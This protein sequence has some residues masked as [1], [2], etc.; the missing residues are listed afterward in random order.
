MRRLPATVAV[1]AIAT[2][3]AWWALASRRS[4]PGVAP[5]PTSGDATSNDEQPPAL[6]AAAGRE[7]VAPELGSHGSLVGIVRRGVARIA[8]RVEIRDPWS[9]F[10]AQGPPTVA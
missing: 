6:L 8:A 2:L 1:V 4:A 5:L 10:Q 7:L 9:G 3:V